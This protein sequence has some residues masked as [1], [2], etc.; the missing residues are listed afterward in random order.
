MYNCDLHFKVARDRYSGYPLTIEGFAYL[1]AG[2]RATYGARQGRVCYELKVN[3][4]IPVKH[5][6]P[7]EPDPHVVRVGWSL[8]SCSTQLGEEPFSYG[9]GGTAKK[10]TDCRFESYGEPFAEND[11]IACLLDFE[12]GDTIKLSFLKNGRWLGRCPH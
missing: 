11:V 4:E 7:T 1:W 5:L 6:P 2:A 10:S 12:V 8:D 3:E 9:Y